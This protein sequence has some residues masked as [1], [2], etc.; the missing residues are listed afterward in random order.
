MCTGGGMLATAKTQSNVSLGENMI[1]AGLFVQVVFFGFFIIVSIVFHRRMLATPAHAVRATPIPW[2]RYMQVLYT[3]SV[4][5]M[6]RSLYRVVEY[7]QGSDGYLQS[8]EA[9]I[10]VFDA[11]L[12]LISCLVFNIFHPSKIVSSQNTEWENK[13]DVEMLNTNGYSNI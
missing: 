13:E 11:T 3:V 1:I 2:T 4:L 7:I 6:I 5:I 8:H 10:Y 12:M 9:F